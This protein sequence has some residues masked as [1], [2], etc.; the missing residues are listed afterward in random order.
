MKTCQQSKA[1]LL[2]NE[3]SLQLINTTVNPCLIA[4]LE[5]THCTLDWLF[6][7]HLAFLLYNRIQHILCSMTHQS[8]AFTIKAQWECHFSLSVLKKLLY[9]SCLSLSYSI[10]GKHN[11]K[12][13]RSALTPVLSWHSL[14]ILEVIEVIPGPLY[15]N[16]QLVNRT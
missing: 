13:I 1:G 8:V 11:N 10:N 6:C 16:S 2:Q 5:N 7:W 14:I 3:V 4:A 12:C 9:N 15:S